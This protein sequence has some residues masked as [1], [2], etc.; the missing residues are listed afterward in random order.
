MTIEPFGWKQVNR[1]FGGLGAQPIAYA[2]MRPVSDCR[3][4][5]YAS[6]V[7]QNTGDPTTIPLQW[8]E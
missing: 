6:V 4:W 3:A 2:T 1:V 8:Q 5:A 7:D